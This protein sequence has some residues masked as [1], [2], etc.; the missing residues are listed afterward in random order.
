MSSDF[1][2]EVIECDVKSAGKPK[3][4][5]VIADNVNH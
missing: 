4:E 3:R 2:E 5:S 1:V